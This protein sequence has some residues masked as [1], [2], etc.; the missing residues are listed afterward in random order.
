MTAPTKD[1]ILEA[2]ARLYGEH[3]FRGTT[4][5]RIAQEAGVNEVTLFRQF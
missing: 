4:T 2:A 3:G 1:H 5:R